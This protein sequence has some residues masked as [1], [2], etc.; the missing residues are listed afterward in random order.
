MRLRVWTDLVGG[1]VKPS[2][3]ALLVALAAA[4]VAVAALTLPANAQGSCRLS[5]DFGALRSHQT[6]THVGLLNSS[7]CRFD[8]VRYYDHYSFQLTGAGEIRLRL[9]SPDFPE[10][11]AL[12]TNSGEFLAGQNG[13]Y[14]LA[15]TLPAGRYRL[16]AIS[17]GNERAG[18]YT[19][20]IRTGQLA[21]PPPTPPPPEPTTTGDDADQDDE[22][23]VPPGDPQVV[24]GHVIAR[25]HPLPEN[26]QRGRYRIEFGFLSAEV[27]SSGTDRTAVVDANTHLLPPQ[28]YLNEASL[29]A[30]SRA[31]DRRWLR[32]SPVD[33]LPLEGDDASLGG[34]PLLTGRIIARW[35]PTDGGVFRVEFGFLP[36]WAFVAA[37]DDTQR[38]AEL[39]AHLLPEPGRYLWESRINS[40]LRRDQPR[41]LTSSVVKIDIDTPPPP[42]GAVTITPAG[43]PIPLSWG[44]RIS[45]VAIAT[46]SGQLAE[47]F[48]PVVVSGLPPGLTYDVDESRADRCEYQVTVSGTI[49]PQTPVRTYNVSITVEG[50]VGDPTTETVLVGPGT[51]L[52]PIFIEWGG[53]NPAETSIRGSVGIVQPRVVSPFPAPPGV[54]WSFETRTTD[55]CSVDSRTG[56]LTLIGAGACQVTVTASAPGYRPATASADV[57]VGDAPIPTLIWSG[58]N[59]STIGVSD[60]APRILPRRALVNGREVY[61]TYRYSVAPGSSDVCRV[62]EATG[63]LTITGVGECRINLTNLPKPPEYGAGRASASVQVR[64]GTGV[65]QWAGY[66]PENVRLGDTAPTLLPPTGASRSVQF[67]YQSITPSICSA[68][69]ATGRLTLIAEGTCSVTLSASGDPN[70]QYTPVT[71]TVVVT[72][73]VEAPRIDSINCSPSRPNVGDRVTCRAQLSDGEPDEWQ[74]FGGNSDGTD[75]PTYVTTF[76]AEGR[77]I[78]SLWVSN[79]AGSANAST[80]VDVPPGPSV[81]DSITCSPSEPDVGQTVTCRARLSGGQLDGWDWDDSGRSGAGCTIDRESDLV[82]CGGDPSASSEEY[83]T[84]FSQTGRQTV[85]LTVRNS[86]GSDRDFATVMVPPSNQD[87][88]CLSVRDVEYDEDATRAVYVECTDPDGDRIELRAQSSNTRAVTIDDSRHPWVYTRAAGPG[89][90]TITVTATDGRG[91]S[92][93]VRFTV[94]IIRGGE[95]PRVTISCPSSAEENERIDCTWSLISGDQPTS[96]SWSDSDGGSGSRS[97]YRVSFAS[98]GTKTVY[99]T[100]SNTSGSDSRRQTTVRVMRVPPPNSGPEA[101]GSIPTLT[102]GVGW[103]SDEV[104]LD[105]YFRDPDGDSLTYEV[106]SSNSSRA[107]VRVVGRNRDELTV[108]GRRAGSVTITVTASDGKGGT[109]TQSFSATAAPRPSWF[110]YCQPDS[111]RVWYLRGAYGTRHHLDITASQAEDLWGSSWW[112]EIATMSSSDCAKWPIGPSY[113][114]NDA[115]WEVERV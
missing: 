90:S 49:P 33:V 98:P 43:V 4:L 106:D 70:R 74:W 113:D 109:A 60:P 101:V 21:P 107:S 104:D 68:E 64:M 40:E 66:L 9:S 110:V 103:G 65:I 63:A 87:P 88:E 53:Y 6:I 79:S 15:R 31:N 99:L 46:V 36:N 8:G 32:S 75:D 27:L 69:R 76:D 26:D 28:R 72:S 71:R 83:S 84:T 50:A 100:A 56:A 47:T 55:V 102:V 1:G 89:S 114:Y 54:V 92:D 16:L 86:A 67:S 77:Q 23:V 96:W 57:T 14:E 80:I 38:A 94:T 58:Y 105:S 11:I 20:T 17:T 91:G 22:Q 42:C 85:W 115:R 19:L 97:D 81:I 34:E 29:L 37:G 7:S 10:R 2:T 111:I 62:N 41:W 35:S 44:E 25:V 95:P 18:S 48:Q 93:E 45:D 82:L 24:S 13:T 108:T 12:N 78:V 39:Y 3:K 73:R 59:P 5:K 61:P 112:S 30:R 51:E 52:P